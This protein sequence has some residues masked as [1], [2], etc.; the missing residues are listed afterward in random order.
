MKISSRLT[1]C[2]SHRTNTAA[3]TEHK[4]DSC[5]YTLRFAVIKL[6]FFELLRYEIHEKRFTPA[7]FFTAL[8]QDETRSGFQLEKHH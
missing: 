3:K 6:N 2:I 8:L 1:R 7:M 5:H 4:N